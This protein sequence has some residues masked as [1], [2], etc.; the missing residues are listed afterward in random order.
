[1]EVEIIKKIIISGYYGF[2]N[3]GDEAILAA[4][5]QGLK[6]FIQ[7]EKIKLI[8]LSDK[9]QK[10]SQ[11]HKIDAIGRYNLLAL[12]KQLFSADLFISG[13]GGLLQDVTGKFSISYYLILIV[14]AKILGCKTFFAAQG[15]GPV[16]SKFNRFLIAI[17]LNQVEQIT[18]RDR[19]SKQLLLK[20]GVKKDI[21]VAADLALSLK[22]GSKENG[23][24]LLNQAGITV[25]KSIVLGIVVRKW[26]QND[27]LPQLAKL[28]NYLSEKYN[29]KLLI[30]PF[31]VSSD[32]KVSYKL[33]N[34]IK[35]PV[36]LLQDSYCPLEMIDIIKTLDFLIGIRLHALIFA[37]LNRVPVAAISYDPK[38]NN[39][40]ARV[41]QKAVADIN[42]LALEQLKEKITSLW[43]QKELLLA[44]SEKKIDDL[45]G[46][47]MYNLEIALRL[48]GINEAKN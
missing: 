37:I 39:F 33:K 32:L 2:D 18:V 34:L 15:V 5:C 31:K 20:W 40:L 19:Q 3:L 11:Q 30:I 25:D 41:N 27:Y 13:G 10:T 26:R 45:A 24:K 8:A 1:M 4:W 47:S 43:E 14:L 22:E 21:C 35:Q 42:S 28:L 12:I 46:L 16:S 44:K 6:K 38:I 29:F 36:Q 23:L 17:I 9:P 48:V 7:S